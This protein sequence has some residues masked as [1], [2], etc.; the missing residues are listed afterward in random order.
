MS[1]DKSNSDISEDISHDISEDNLE[2]EP[3][4]SEIS[5]GYTCPICQKT[6]KTESSLRGHLMRTHRTRSEGA[7]TQ[8]LEG[9]IPDA[10]Q[11]LEQLLRL[12]VSPRDAQAIITFLQPYGP[13]NIPKLWEALGNLNVPLNRRRMIIESWCVSRSLPLPESLRRELGIQPMPS[14]GPSS[15]YGF[16]P[17]GL[18]EQPQP[19]REDLTIFDYLLK[20]EQVK[21]TQQPQ[22]Q[23]IQTNPLESQMQIQTLQEQIR[24]LKES[25]EKEI[26]GLRA[27]LQKEREERLFSEIR[28]LEDKIKSIEARPSTG[29][30]ADEYRLL[31]DL[32]R[33]I[34]S[35]NP[36]QQFLSFLDKRLPELMSYAYGIPQEKMQQQI[37]QAR[38][39]LLEVLRQKGLTTPQ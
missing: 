24:D 25:Y 30:T 39:G 28:R 22:P 20:W 34:A 29:Y 6:F 13:D 1:N 35:K 4:I 15:G 23:T 19:K 38:L 7:P 9:P 5:E 33:E 8:T 26:E 21:Q 37:P 12:F 3:Q 11:S 36:M 18:Y 27:E 2:T 32:G 16:S 10:L 17:Y 31:S 14:F